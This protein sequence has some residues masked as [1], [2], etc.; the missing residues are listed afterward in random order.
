MNTLLN[1]IFSIVS[2]LVVLGI[3]VL[4]HELGHYVAG[5]LQGFAVEAFSIG[6]GPKL[7]EHRG[8]YNLLQVR[9]LL[10]GGYVKF[11]DESGE[12]AQDGA[13]W[14]GPGA[15][16]MTKKRWK[17]FL[18]MLMGAAFNV[19]LAYGL[20]AGLAMKGWDESVFRNQ[21][22][23]IGWVAPEL[24]AAKAGV[25]A[26]DLIDSIDGRHISNWEEARN[27]IY[28]NQQPYTLI[29]KRN[30][31]KISMPITPKVETVY[32]QPVGEIGVF[33]AFLPVIGSLL[34]G[35]PAFRAGLKPGDRIISVDG[36][37]FKYWGQLRRALVKG[38]GRIRRF[39]VERKGAKLSFSIKP[40]WNKRVKRFMVGIGPALTVWIRYPFPS[41]LAK[42]WRVVMEQSTLA[43]RTIQRL[44]ERKLS[45]KA[46][47]GPVSIAYITGRVARTGLYNFLMLLG[48]ISLQLGIFN[49]LPIPGLDGGQI[50]VL[51]IEGTA[52]RDLPAGIKD[53]II[54]TGFV[55]VILLISVIT[56]LD[57]TKFIH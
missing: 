35:S 12:T 41:N 57:V 30:G 28:L 6:F 3:L 34:K 53:K 9:W 37:T 47:S 20:F 1:V 14:N 52:R 5:R 55:L 31:A 15:P 46:L 56:L 19:L 2:F 48:I 32:H 10:L 25:R 38:G 50:L 22:A 42:A 36:E 33:P 18:V 51:L 29:V 45:L 11:V 39:V 27:A 21:K 4:I 54:M 13:V 44:I 7:W 26:G 49:L 8:K 17:R 24:P 40:E 43:F 23:V 16:F